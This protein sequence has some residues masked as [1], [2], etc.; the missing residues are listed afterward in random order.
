MHMIFIVVQMTIAVIWAAIL[1]LHTRR[2][3]RLTRVIAFA[4]PHE[5]VLRY[6][7]RRAWFWLGREEFWSAVKHDSLYCSQVSLMLVLLVWGMS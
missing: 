2:L 4:A 7:L 3:V 1:G 6:R 5:R